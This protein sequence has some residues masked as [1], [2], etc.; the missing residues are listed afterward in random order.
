MSLFNRL[1][2]RN[3]GAVQW[4]LAV[5]AGVVVFAVFSNLAGCSLPAG[6]DDTSTQTSDANVDVTSV[7]TSTA[8]IEVGEAV[9]DITSDTATSTTTTT[10]DESTSSTSTPETSSTT[11]TE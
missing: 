2:P 11:T 6:C 7:T 3:W 4:L 10:I 5:L 9:S 1:D 8:T